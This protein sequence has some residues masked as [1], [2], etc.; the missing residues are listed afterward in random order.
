M[1][2]L[3]TVYAAEKMETAVPHSKGFTNDLDCLEVRIIHERDHDELKI[4]SGLKN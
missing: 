1:V 3:C 4:A 2:V